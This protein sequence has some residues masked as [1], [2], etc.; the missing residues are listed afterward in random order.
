[1]M[2]PTVFKKTALMAVAVGS[3]GFAMPTFAAEVPSTP[4]KTTRPAAAR[5]APKAKPAGHPVSAAAKPGKPAKPTTPPKVASSKQQRLDARKA[6]AAQRQAAIDQAIANKD[7][8]AWKAAISTGGKDMGILKL[9][10]ADNFSRYIDMLTAQ[11]NKDFKTVQ[12]IR[13]ELGFT[14]KAKPAKKK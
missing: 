12:Q 8:A 11:K 6:E 3:I 5:Q 9:V 1:M 4:V 10:T 2:T 7:F 13:Q 14:H